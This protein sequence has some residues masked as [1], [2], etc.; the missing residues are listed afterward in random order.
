M[1]K[2]ITCHL[3]QEMELLDKNNNPLTHAKYHL[4]KVKEAGERERR[5]LQLEVAA[6]LEDQMRDYL[7]QVS[8]HITDKY[9]LLNIHLSCLYEC[10]VYSSRFVCTFGL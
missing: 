3:V 2:C 8:F 10:T 9:V 5:P 4:E 1:L 6:Y 7:A